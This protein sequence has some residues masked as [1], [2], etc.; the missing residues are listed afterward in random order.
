[1]KNLPAAVGIKPSSRH[2]ASTTIRQTLHNET[3]SNYFD[4]LASCR[5]IQQH[6]LAV[7]SNCLKVPGISTLQL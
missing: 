3:A 4:W 1:L 7:S 6:L 2:S 5:Q